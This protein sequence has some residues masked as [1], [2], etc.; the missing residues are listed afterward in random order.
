MRARVFQLQ[1]N[2]AVRQIFFIL[3]ISIAMGLAVNMVRTDSIPVIADWSTESRLIS[4]GDESLTLP[5]SQARELFKNNSAI[6]LDARDENSFDQGHI[7]GAK[8]LPWNAV[9]EYFMDVAKGLPKDVPII[10][11]CDGESCN[12][13][14]ELA[15]FL[16][17]MGFTNVKVLVNGWTVWQEMNL[18]V[19]GNLFARFLENILI[20]SIDALHPKALGPKASTNIHALMDKGTYTLDGSS[21]TPPLTLLSH[22]AMFTGLGPGESGKT[23]N[24]W[25][26]GQDRVKPETIFTL[27]KSLGFSTGFFYSKEKLGFLVNGAIDHHKLS[28]GFSVEHAMEFF[29]EPGKNFCFLH[30]SG[31]DQAGPTEGWMSAGY[32]EELFYIDESIAPLIKMIENKENYLLIVTSDHAGHRLIHG[33]DHPE[34]AMLPLV[35]VS[36]IVNL[37]SYQDMKYK[38]TQLKSIL[39][40]IVR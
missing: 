14:H 21:T 15:L 24:G 31:L 7:K 13:S 23:D 40:T 37:K 9:D 8:N 16:N 36:D 12:L 38:V 17:E 29:K 18:P 35:L 33:S 27:G 5:I 11:Y 34:D 22:T 19:G 10:T 2:N 25:Q 4:N 1:L 26:P 39:E 28:N 32:M 3:V 20:I 6:F 30:I